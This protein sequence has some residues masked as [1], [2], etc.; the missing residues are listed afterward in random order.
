VDF[1][2]AYF[3]TDEA[4]EPAA[5]AHLAEERGFE[6]VFVTEHTHIPAS[7]DTAYPAGG[8]LP[9][10]YFRIH[11]PF[12]SLATM[13]QATE[14]IK[15]GTAI[16]LLVERDPIVTAKEVASV[17]RLSGGR[18]I[19]GVGA[20]WNLEEM[21]NHGTDPERR[22]KI[23][24]ERIEACKEMWANEEATYHGEFVNFDRIVSRPGPLQEPH[25]PVL[26]G[27]NGPNVLKR[28]LASGDGWFPNRIPP[29][30]QMI[31]RVEELQRL[32][33]EAGRGPIPVTLQIPPRDPDVLH[34]YEE[35][36]VTRTVHMLRPG[37]AADAGSAE[38]KLDEWTERIQAYQ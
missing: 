32:G 19:F 16:C 6:S 12:V 3:P 30:D 24:R 23:L 11:D 26:I 1:G 13:A 36:G 20:G 28:V 7:R 33:E 15:V 25:P 2:I 27:G 38:R 10:E 37:D 4:I 34:R 35:A 29:D 17:D 31:G 21:R 14:R 22:F 5:L 8:E 9:R 18:M